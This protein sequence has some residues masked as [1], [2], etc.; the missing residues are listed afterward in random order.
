MGASIYRRLLPRPRR[1]T[2]GAGGWSPPS[3]VPWP[4][5]GLSAGLCQTA[6]APLRLAFGGGSA[7]VRAEVE[8]GV[9]GSGS[10]RLAVEPGGVR[11]AAAD[12]SG[13]RHGLATLA[14]MVRLV[15]GGALPCVEIED[16]PAFAVRGFMLDISRDRV[17]TMA[18]LYQLVDDMAGLKLNRL[19]LYTEHAFA[20]A[21][22]ERVWR[23]AD[24]ITPDEME[25][26]DRY[27]GERGVELG[28]N[29][30]TLGHFERWLRVPEYAD[31]GETDGPIVCR[32][33]WGGIS[34]SEPNTL[35]PLDRRSIEL[36]SGLLGQLLPCC[37]GGVVNIGC[38]EPFDL[39]YG[40]SKDECERIGRAAVFS[41]YVAKVAEAVRRLGR[42]PAFWCDP[43]PNEDD[44][45]P[46][47]LVALVW[48]YESTTHFADR[49]R[50][51]I[52]QGREAWVCPGT[53]S[54]NAI[55]SRTWNRRGN[56]DAAVGEGLAVGA[57]GL[58]NT[59]WGDHGHRQQW[60]LTLLGMADGAQACWSGRPGEYDSEAAGIHLLGG[61]ALGRWLADL[62]DADEPIS[63]G[64]E[65]AG[66][67]RLS[68]CTALFQEMQ[69]RAWRDAA[70]ADEAP[71]WRGVAERL[72]VLDRSLA[73]AG[74]GVEELV[75]RECRHAVGLARWVADRAVLRRTDPSADH[76]RLLMERLTPL[77]G[78]HRRLWL[79]RSRY[80]G[81]EDSTHHYR[82][83]IAS[84]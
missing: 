30:N 43:H 18:S 77:I 22:H 1:V 21:G 35:C 74:T 82:R 80:G 38:D 68:N 45:L 24:P 8:P 49:L 54:W 73:E 83:L 60:P 71:A 34:Y 39:G 72:T 2:P 44:S 41:G 11:L 76:R 23:A 16:A 55:T 63:S 28:A 48:G 7:V 19:E 57:T 10:Y 40:R 14:Q 53:S 50:S 52:G 27:A 31:L 25:A 47:D 29:Q 84:G 15:G 46:R 9:G 3:G 20:Y 67:P 62:G 69:H 17:P 79:A 64:R 58:L 42:R 78:E 12:Q 81:L 56:L 6:P 36:V 13:L 61:A 59:E 75:M 51:H 32:F 66:G 4:T 5:V 37:S 33:P 65:P 26:L 70:S